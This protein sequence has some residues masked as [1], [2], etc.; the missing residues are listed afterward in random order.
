MLY[1]QDWERVKELYKAWWK[2]EQEEALI[3]VTASRAGASGPRGWSN[4]ELVRD[5]DPS[6]VDTKLERF[7][8]YCSNTFFGGTAFPLLW[9]NL[10]PGVLAAYLTDYLLYDPRT[11][12]SWFEVKLDWESIAALEFKEDN[13]WWQYTKQVAEMAVEESNGDFIVG[14]TDLGGIMDVIA[15]LRTSAQLLLDLYDYPEQ[16]SS[17]SAWI[18]DLWHRCFDEL[19]AIIGKAECGFSA[20]MGL[21]HEEPWYPIQC[22]FSAMISPAM[23]E[24]F[25]LPQ[26]EEQVRRLPAAVY[27][28][29][30]P[31]EVPHLDMLLEIDG[32]QG[33]QWVPV[34]FDEYLTSESIALFR[35]ILEK[36]NLVMHVPDWK[37]VLELLEV[38]PHRGLLLSTSCQT[39]AEARYLLESAAKLRHKWF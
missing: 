6:A 29:D 35:K 7:R 20:W 5:P 25:V 33:I 14:V 37:T 39:E 36:K 28:L 15:S 9:I 11:E 16:I 2:Q 31:G 19:T 1:N 10:G 4:W 27:H 18:I 24:K 23:F 38:L 34:R 26:L 17:A 13:R 21:W 32:I 8:D 30:G 3:S 12:T 22:D